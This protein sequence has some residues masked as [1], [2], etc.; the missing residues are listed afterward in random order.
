MLINDPATY[1]YDHILAR[2]LTKGLVLRCVMLFCFVLCCVV[3]CCLVL[4]CPIHV[5]FTHFILFV[6]SN[7]F[8]CSLQDGR[9]PHPE[10][11]HFELLP[12]R[13]ILWK[14]RFDVL[15]ARVFLS[16]N[17]AEIQSIHPCCQHVLHSTVF[18]HFILGFVLC[19]ACVCVRAK[20]N[21]NPNPNPN[22]KV[23]QSA[24]CSMQPALC[25]C[26]TLK[27]TLPETTIHF[28]GSVF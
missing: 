21:P 5:R 27:R 28:L 17:D 6:T 12:G 10:I 25:S 26:D 23:T 9:F 19:A 7:L 24:V 18:F 14:G 4:S 3:S 11:Y 22:P 15:K 2:N 16:S 8:I 13:A 1:D 20:P